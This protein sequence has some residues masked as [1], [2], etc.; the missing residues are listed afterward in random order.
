V[1]YL[2]SPR[3]E[4]EV[5]TRENRYVRIA[6]AEVKTE[7]GSLRHQALFCKSCGSVL[8]DGWQDSHERL[9]PRLRCDE[10]PRRLH[11]GKWHP[12]GHAW[13]EQFG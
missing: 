9:H 5:L 13:E 1:T 2:E 6:F 4:T 8:M 3:Q 7:D 12:E 11:W 10:M